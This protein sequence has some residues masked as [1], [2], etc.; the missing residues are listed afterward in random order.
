MTSPHSDRVVLF[1]LDGCILDSTEPVLHDVSLDVAPGDGVA[2]SW[3]CKLPDG[4]SGL[5]LR[6]VSGTGAAE[7]VHVVSGSDEV[8]ALSVP[9]LARHGDVLVAAW[10]EK[11]ADGSAIASALLPIAALR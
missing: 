11:T 9:Q 8:P 3:T 7:P 2:V 1:D 6:A 10:T 5:C 4:S